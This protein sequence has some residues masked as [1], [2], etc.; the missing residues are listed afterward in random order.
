MANQE[1]SWLVLRH[2][3]S[4]FNLSWVYIRDFNEIKLGQKSGGAI[5]PE[6]Q[7]QNFRD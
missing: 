5:R 4:Q 3:S 6:N 1:D 7:M 2:L